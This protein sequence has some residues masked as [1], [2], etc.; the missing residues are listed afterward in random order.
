MRFAT[1]REEN[2]LLVEIRVFSVFRPS[3]YFFFLYIDIYTECLKLRPRFPLQALWARY[4]RFLRIKAIERP[5]EKGGKA[6]PPL[7]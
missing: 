3:Q 2:W 7:H 6:L 4:E 1:L 5:H